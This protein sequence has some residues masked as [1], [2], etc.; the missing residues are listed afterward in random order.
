M[1]KEKATITLKEFLKKG[2]KFVIP[3]YQRGYIW[4]K[5]RGSEKNSVQYVLESIENSIK[6]DTDL[7]MQGITVTESDDKIVLIDGQ[8]RTTFFYLL[9]SYLG[10][11]E[12][13]EMEY[14]IRE[15][16][17]KF[18]TV[19]KEKAPNEIDKLCIEN[20]K[21]DFQDIYY[22][23]KTIRLISD[24]KDNLDKDKI[25]EKV[26]FLYITI[27]EDKATLVFSMMNGSKADMK[28]EEIIKAEIL[29][30]VSIDKNL[31]TDKKE[32]EA[33][34]WEQNL[35][36]SKYAREWDKWLYWWNRDDVE[37]FYH[38]NKSIMGLL[39]KTY[40]KSK[41]GKIDKEGRFF[42]E[43][44]DKLLRG[45][46]NEHLA[47]KVFYDLRHLQKKFEDVFNSIADDKK[48]HNKI[49]AILTLLGNEDKERFVQWY[50]ANDEVKV[51]EEYYKLV[52]LGLSHTV[53]VG[54]KNEEIKEA[55]YEMLS[56]LKSDNLYNEDKNYAFLQLLRRNIEEDT[57]LERPFCFSIWNQKSLEHIFPKSKV[58]HKDDETGKNM[59][60]V[61]GEN[62]ED[63]ELNETSNELLDRTFFNQNGSEH[64]I[65]NLVLLYK[66]E[67]SKFG[68]KTVEEKKNIYFT[69][70]P[71][72]ETKKFKSRHLLHTISV[73]A[74][75]NWSLEKNPEGIP[76]V[77]STIQK[78]KENFI[79]EIKEYYG[80]Q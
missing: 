20:D 9:L 26:N 12:Q 53:I 46:N 80:I 36:R 30:L 31:E 23:K 50:F 37:K 6:Y 65:G 11:K 10:Y 27:P 2:K 54:D 32:L 7:F 8:Q 69:P 55:K 75:N 62:K 73:F 67:N 44:R 79:N 57:R 34:H 47:K 59:V 13:F 18:L 48:L 60:G 77:V 35:L 70:D 29:R 68:A 72:D 61:Y 64:C 49:G 24:R 42:E 76:Y 78:N 5:S 66:N 33:T 45:D 25:L 43:F 40:L 56:A 21:E 17:Q 15:E 52:F 16:S 51:I 71:K 41:G 3:T 63:V 4:G 28:T 39:V 58:Y 1:Y 19:I 74:N 38:T 14:P 22:F